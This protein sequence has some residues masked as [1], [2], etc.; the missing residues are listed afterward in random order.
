[1][2]RRH[3]RRAFVANVNNTW[4]QAN[5]VAAMRYKENSMILLQVKS[6]KS[7]N[8]FYRK[9]HLP[10]SN[11]KKKMFN[12][13][14]SFFFY[15]DVPTRIQC[16]KHIRLGNWKFL[17]GVHG[18]YQLHITIHTSCKFLV[19]NQLFSFSLRNNRKILIN[20]FLTA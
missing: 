19:T 20:F 6:V 15:T 1:M 2:S 5:F 14:S 7:P 11:H 13:S 4:N 9:I 18:K 3:L 12:I 10:N 17:K 16:I 8:H